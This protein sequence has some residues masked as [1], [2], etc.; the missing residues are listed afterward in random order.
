M[1]KI[2]IAKSQENT[3]TTISL[4]VYFGDCFLIAF[5]ELS[6]FIQLRIK[7]HFCDFERT[8]TKQMP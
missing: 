4:E 7:I 2:V 5:I 8:Y 1:Y 3:M 6:N